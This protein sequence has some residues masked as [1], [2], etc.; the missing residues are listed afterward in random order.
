MEEMDTSVIE[1]PIRLKPDFSMETLKARKTQTDIIKCSE[2]S[3]MS[4]QSTIPNKTINHNRWRK[5]TTQQY[6]PIQ[7]YSKHKKENFSLKRLPHPRKYK[8]QIIP[9][10]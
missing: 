9:E 1:K 2:R 6:L 10:E 4:A 3:K 8:E 7:F 5:K